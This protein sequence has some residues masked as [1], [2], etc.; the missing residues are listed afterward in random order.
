MDYLQVLTT[1]SSCSSNDSSM[2]GGQIGDKHPLPAAAIRSLCLFAVPILIAAQP[3]RGGGRRN[4]F[5]PPPRHGDKM[6]RRWQK[7]TFAS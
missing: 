2:P 6:E 7:V 5:P 4:P 3:H 1:T